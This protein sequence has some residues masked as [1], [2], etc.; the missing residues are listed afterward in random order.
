MKRL[1]RAIFPIVSILFYVNG[2]AQLKNASVSQLGFMTGIWVQ[3]T[4]SGEIEEFWGKPIGDNMVS[5][6]RYVKNGKVAFYEFVV[7]EQTD[8]VPVMRI[9]HYNRGSIGWEDKND[10]LNM[11]LASL[12]DNEAEFIS[13]NGAVHLI[14]KRVDG[15][16]LQAILNE[17]GKDGVWNKEVFSYKLTQ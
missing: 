2:F 17:K 15:E 8:T 10:P 9:R 11:P 12:T 5:S 7:I 16:N 14:Y 3:K 4:V 13:L 1:F 6:F